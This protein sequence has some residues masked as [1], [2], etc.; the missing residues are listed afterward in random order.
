M[1]SLD[2]NWTL[3]AQVW[4]SDLAKI[5]I[6]FNIEE[7]ESAEYYELHN[8]QDIGGYHLQMWG[9]GRLTRDPAIF[10]NTQ[11]EY[12]G[13]ADNTYGWVNEEYAELI[14]EAKVELDE[15]KRR[16]MYQRLNEIIVTKSPMIQFHT[17]VGLSV[18]SKKLR[19]MTQDLI[20]TDT[21][22][23]AY[24]ED[25][26]SIAR[27]LWFVG[28]RGNPLVVSGCSHTTA[29]GAPSGTGGGRRQSSV[30]VL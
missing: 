2:P 1:T 23:H 13:G 15:D 3:C 28:R 6:T 20:G 12:F 5:G 21:F 26:G 19:G 10:F 22:W 8:D 11:Q 24:I 29:A 14:D 18:A 25:A 17:G 16:E 7:I 4:Q 27:T 9:T 30:M